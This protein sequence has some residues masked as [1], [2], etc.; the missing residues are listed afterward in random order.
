MSLDLLIPL[1]I[2]YNLQQ[3]DV[4]IETKSFISS[5]SFSVISFITRIEQPNFD[6]KFLI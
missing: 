2:L 3:K 1:L 5:V 6:N 4:I